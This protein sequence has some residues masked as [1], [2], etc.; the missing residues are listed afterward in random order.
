MRLSTERTS[1]HP[2]VSSTGF[3]VYEAEKTTAATNNPALLSQLLTTTL[4]RLHTTRCC[5]VAEAT[6]K[7]AYDTAQAAA[8][9]IAAIASTAYLHGAHPED[10]K[11]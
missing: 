7:T 5:Y 8:C 6:A 9:A 3:R 10:L 2:L 1:E 4:Q 11:S